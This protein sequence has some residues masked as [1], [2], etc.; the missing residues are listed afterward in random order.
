MLVNAYNLF[1]KRYQAVSSSSYYG[2]SRNLRATL[3]L[4]F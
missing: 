3:Q 4:R 1:D 2:E